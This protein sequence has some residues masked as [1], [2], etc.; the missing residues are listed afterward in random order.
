VG[1]RSSLPAPHQCVI[2]LGC[3]RAAAVLSGSVPHDPAAMSYII[4]Q[5]MYPMILCVTACY[6]P[7]ACTQGEGILAHNCR[8]KLLPECAL[9]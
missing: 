5:S 2:H 9:R 3:H 6:I 8:T 7:Y 4:L 1:W